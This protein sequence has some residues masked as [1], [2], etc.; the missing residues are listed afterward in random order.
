[1]SRFT[2]LKKFG[3]DVIPSQRQ[4][5]ARRIADEKREPHKMASN[6]VTEIHLKDYAEYPYDVENVRFPD[7]TIED[8][9]RPPI[10]PNRSFPAFSISIR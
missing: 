2:F 6:E 5:R 9:R 10:N 7:S 3:R 8:L 1:M 4:A